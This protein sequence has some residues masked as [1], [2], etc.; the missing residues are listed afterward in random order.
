MERLQR[1]IASYGLTSR[2]KAEQMIVDGRVSVD[3]NVV[4]E[5][6]V[7][8]DPQRQVI[9]VDG[10]LVKWER[11]RYIVLNKPSGYITTAADERGRRTVLELVTVT[12]R[13]VPVGRLDRKTSGL[14]LL[15]NDGELLYRVT[16]PKFEMEKEYEA[17][18]DGFPPPVALER[19]RRGLTVDGVKV[20]PEQVR[21]LRN[22]ESGTILRIVI[23]EGRNRIV[24][25]ML[26]Q[27]GFPAIK[28]E[29]I[30]VG[31]LH[32]RGLPTG[33]WR[34]LTAGELTQIRE[35]VGLNEDEATRDV[36]S[37]PASV[38][39]RRS[40]D[41]QRNG[42][43]PASPRQGTPGGNGTRRPERTGGGQP[44]NRGP[45]SGGP[46]RSRDRRSGGGR[47]EHGGKQ[48]RSPA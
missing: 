44:A 2:R 29:R 41:V 21:P 6:G 37:K 13:V 9:K 4:Q 15:T 33:A 7:R 34:D 1:V 46:S 23:H 18:L 24:R 19:M 43:S 48:T 20:V 40:I 42:R 16:H 47:Q 17:A 26:E 11:R 12:E 25:R 14:L 45:N 5:L 27:I 31:P 8:V 38:D 3:G 30:R 35:S 22:E 32:V 10:K 36:E 28:L 39:R